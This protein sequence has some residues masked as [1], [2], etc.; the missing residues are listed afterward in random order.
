MKKTNLIIRANG[1]LDGREVHEYLEKR[2]LLENV[3]YEISGVAGLFGSRYYFSKPVSYIRSLWICFVLGIKTAQ[4]G[5]IQI[6][7]EN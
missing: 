5:E 2:K 1:M 7:K 4:Y 6:F 3:K